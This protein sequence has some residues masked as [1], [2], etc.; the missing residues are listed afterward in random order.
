MSDR[1]VADERGA[2]LKLL[3]IEEIRQLKARYFRMLDTKDWDGFAAVFTPDAVLDSGAWTITGSETI[4]D[5]VSASLEGI[6]TVH[7][8]HTAEITIDS[9]TTAHAIW[10]MAD[11]LHAGGHP[12]KGLTGSGHYHE[13]YTHTDD[14]W[15]ISRSQ[16]T[17]LHISPL[18]GGFHVAIPGDN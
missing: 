5:R 2:M 4:R 12:E 9:P 15:R 7:H 14:G 17:R 13:E 3:A 10:A 16:L 8:G 11:E 6:T 1:T 18:P